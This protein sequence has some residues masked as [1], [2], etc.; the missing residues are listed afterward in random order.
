[1][2]EAQEGVGLS[3][4]R[5]CGEA[6]RAAGAGFGP[7]VGR[8]SRGRVPEAERPAGTGLGRRGRSTGVGLWS[9]DRAVGEATTQPGNGD[10]ERTS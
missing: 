5:G 1:M 8:E 6:S 10:A 9:G 2:P 4:E 7:A 3:E